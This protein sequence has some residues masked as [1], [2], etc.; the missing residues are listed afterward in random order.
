[1]YAPRLGRE[2][3]GGGGNRTRDIQVMSLAIC[4]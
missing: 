1:M 3:N 2:R 4:L